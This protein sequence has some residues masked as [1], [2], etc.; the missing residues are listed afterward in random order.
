MTIVVGAAGLQITAVHHHDAQAQAAVNRKLA[1]H[2]PCFGAP[3]LT[4]DRR[5][6]R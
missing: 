3:A 6:V 4:A 2:D 5:S 1:G